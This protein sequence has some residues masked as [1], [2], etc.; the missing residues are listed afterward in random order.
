MAD[1]HSFDKNGFIGDRGNGNDFNSSG[2]LKK[3]K[4]DE[5]LKNEGIQNTSDW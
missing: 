3:S 2:R 4:Y 1:E 5:I